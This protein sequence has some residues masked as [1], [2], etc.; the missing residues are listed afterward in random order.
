MVALPKL[1]R[2]VVYCEFLALKEPREIELPLGD[3]MKRFSEKT[4]ALRNLHT[5]DTTNLFSA[6][7]FVG[8]KE[9]P[10]KGKKAKWI[11]TNE[12]EN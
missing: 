12:G 8:V 9:L 1:K 5:P 6:M 2:K 3:A 10:K 11:I 7:S 4:K